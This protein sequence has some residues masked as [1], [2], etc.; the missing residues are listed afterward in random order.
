MSAF[1]IKK[2]DVGTQI[3]CLLNRL[4]AVTRSAVDVPF[5]PPLND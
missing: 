2:N 3:C 1:A 4:Q 5:R